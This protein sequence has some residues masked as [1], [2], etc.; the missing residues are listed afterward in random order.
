MTAGQNCLALITHF[1]GFKSTAYQDIAGIWT[2]GYGTTYVAGK[3]VTAG[4]TCTA[5]QAEAWLKD[6]LRDAEQAI[7]QAC[8][9]PLTQYQ[10][11]ALVS[12]VYNIGAGNFHKSS[13]LRVIN[14]GVLGTSVAG[15][16]AIRE[17]QFTAWNKVRQGAQLVEV[18]GLT[19]R[20]KSE[21]HLY[22]MGTI[23]F[24]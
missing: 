10:F 22:S 5:S 19:R 1:E 20:R 4:M 14:A 7:T 21:Y 8:R 16:L 18:P 24:F 11:D 9:V 2:I 3:R 12:L 15:P 13:I 6:S 23:Q 17:A